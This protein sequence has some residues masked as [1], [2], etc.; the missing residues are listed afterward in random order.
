MTASSSLPRTEVSDTEDAR[1]SPIRDYG[2]AEGAAA[3]TLELT[4]EHAL[5][6]WTAVVMNADA[7]GVACR[8][9]RRPVEP[10]TESSVGRDPSLLGLLM[11]AGAVVV[12]LLIVV[13]DPHQR[14]A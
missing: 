11:T 13:V 3:S 12:V 8:P 7:P 6:Q 5:G 9:R 4:R 14:V 2:V 1:P 10:S